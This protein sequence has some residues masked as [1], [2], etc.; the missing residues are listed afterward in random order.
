MTQR[1][2]VGVMVLLLAMMA[3]SRA[4]RPAPPPPPAPAV[5]TEAPPP[6]PPRAPYSAIVPGVLSTPPPGTPTIDLMAVLAAR[7][8]IERE[9]RAVYLDSMLAVTDSILT[10]WVDRGA[11]PLR[12][13]FDLDTT[14]HEV[15]PQVLDAVRGGLAAWQGNPAGLRFVEVDEP[16]SADIV[17]SFTATVSDGGAFGVTNLSWDGIGAATHASIQLALRPSDGA[18]VIHPNMIRRVATHEFGHAVG[19]PHSSERGDVMH[20][21]SPIA[22]PSRRDLA[23]L[24]LLYALPPGSV[25]TP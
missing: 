3:I 4:N 15:T 10:R 19:L 1:L 7:R 12:V 23:T 11:N 16:D 14:Q 13:A 18:P 17:V 24:Q 9:G 21:S 20:P 22:S 5:A 2:L 6:P 25:R 8:R